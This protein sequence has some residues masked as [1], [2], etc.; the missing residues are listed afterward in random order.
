MKLRTK[1]QVFQIPEN[2]IDDSPV[3]FVSPM[4]PKEVKI[5]L[6][7]CSGHEW[8][9]GQRFDTFDYYAF[10]IKKIDKIIGDWKNVEDENGNPLPCTLTNKEIVALYNT[11]LIDKVLAQVDALTKKMEVDLQG[12]EKNS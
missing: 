4:T 1:K 10:R 11:E 6:D 8:D 9:Q 3:F 5:I 2:P 12:T 7:E